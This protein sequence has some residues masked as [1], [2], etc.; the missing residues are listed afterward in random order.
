M[1]CITF[2]ALAEKEV[3]N[4]SDCRRLGN[5][6]DAD[7]DTETGRIL[8]FAVGET[9]MCGKRKQV[10]TVPFDAVRKIGDDIIFVDI[11]LP[12]QPEKQGKGGI[13]GKLSG[14]FG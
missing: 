3:I 9:K 11:C 1:N 5:I 8:S 13:L 12:P 4:M 14:L 2:S 10:F 6:L 7:V